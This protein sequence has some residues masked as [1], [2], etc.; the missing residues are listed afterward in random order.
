M[1]AVIGL[2]I[3]SFAFRAVEVS[4]KNKTNPPQYVLERA[5]EC[6]KCVDT[7]PKKMT[8]NL[9][10]FVK[11]AGFGTKNAVLALP[12]S[13][14]FSTIL[15]IPLQTEKEIKNYLEIEGSKIFPRP[16]SELFYSFVILGPNENNKTEMDVNV[17]VS[18]QEFVNGLF[19]A[20]KNAGLTVLGI[21]S[22]A[23]AIVRAL[24]RSQVLA[25]NDALLVVNVGLVDV[26]MMV[27]RNGYVRFSRNVGLGGTTFN[28]AIAQALAVTEEQAEEYKKSYGLDNVA[29]E[30]KIATAMKPVA[31][32]LITEVKRTM[33]FYSSRNSFCEFKKV[34]FSGGS[35][36]M[37]G[38]LAYSAENLGMEVELANPFVNIEFSSRVASRRDELLNLGPMYTVAMGLALKEI[39]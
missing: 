30:G 24:S 28:K 32:T 8:E 16:L 4:I 33:T 34:V 35:A 13:H 25:P 11:D 37:P 2:D 6:D 22:E 9:K 36:V 21:E 3:G 18:G 14:V 12:E 26:D 38:L 20:A 7:D 39:V 29:M 10:H 15:N 5:L 31:E 23:Y 19:A 17:V 1:P 27:L